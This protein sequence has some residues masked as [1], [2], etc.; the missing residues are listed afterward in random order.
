MLSK[1][2]GR[3]C[4]YVVPAHALILNDA[5]GVG[6]SGRLERLIDE[7]ECFVARILGE[8]P[9]CRLIE[10]WQRRS[11]LPCSEPVISQNFG[12]RV[13]LCEQRCDTPVQMPFLR[14]RQKPVG[15]LADESV[16]KLPIAGGLRTVDKR[17]IVEPRE[18]GADIELG[19]LIRQE[20]RHEPLLETPPLRGGNAQHHL[21][22]L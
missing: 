6:L 15:R 3:T 11:R 13:L 18:G 21:V 7:F 16:L 14:P 19:H 1:L 20:R 10:A 8:G 2:A 4:R 17:R 9:L 12:P 22:E 5:P